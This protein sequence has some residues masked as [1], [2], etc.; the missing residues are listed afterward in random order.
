MQARSVR[1]GSVSYLVNYVVVAFESVLTAAARST[2]VR[3]WSSLL[4]ATIAAG[5]VAAVVAT[6]AARTMAPFGT[7]AIDP[8]AAAGSGHAD[9]TRHGC[10]SAGHAVVSQTTGS[11]ARLAVHAHRHR[12]TFKRI[13]ALA[14]G[15][16]ADGRT[17]AK[18]IQITMTNGRAVLQRRKYININ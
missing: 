6:E 3:L 9:G 16:F 17:K 11:R 13:N 7:F 12:L 14:L 4:V 1:V 18:T 5:C 10:E 2:P 15:Y 8:L